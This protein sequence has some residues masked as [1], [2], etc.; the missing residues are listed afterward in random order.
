MEINQED[1]QKIVEFM[2]LNSCFIDDNYIPKPIGLSLIHISE[3][4]RPY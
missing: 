4:T 3:P 1:F 2:S